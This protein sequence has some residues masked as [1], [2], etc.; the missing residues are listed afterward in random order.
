M[1]K[2]KVRIYISILCFVKTSACWEVVTPHSLYTWLTTDH[3]TLLSK[4][5]VDWLRYASITQGGGASS[6]GF[7]T[8][9][10][11][12]Q[13]GNLHYT[14]ILQVFSCFSQLFVLC[15][16]FPSAD[17][18]SWAGWYSVWRL[19]HCA[20][21][22]PRLHWR[23]VDECLFLF[24]AAPLASHLPLCLHWQH[25][26]WH[27]Y[28]LL[29]VRYQNILSTHAREAHYFMSKPQTRNIRVVVQTMKAVIPL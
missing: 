21:C 15:V 6:G 2:R 11:L 17:A 7:F 3:V 23:P 20:V 26:S 24:H 13:V 10:R 29:A 9:P 1:E 28:D 16:R 14:V 27:W 5:L 18:C 22:G 8:G 12:R 25:H 19:L 4:K